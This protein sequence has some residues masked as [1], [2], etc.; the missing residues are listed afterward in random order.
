MRELSTTS[1]VIDELGG[2]TAVARLLGMSLSRVSNWRAF[3]HFPPDTF[4]ALQ[5][6]LAE[7]DATAPASLWRQMVPPAQA[8]E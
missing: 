5:A 2:T 3:E 6:A 8:A 1:E 4:V 7:R